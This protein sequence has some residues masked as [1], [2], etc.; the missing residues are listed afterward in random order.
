M[1]SIFFSFEVSQS[2]NRLLEEYIV[3]KLFTKHDNQNNYTEHNN[4]GG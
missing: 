3:Y 1:K 4:E 2:Y